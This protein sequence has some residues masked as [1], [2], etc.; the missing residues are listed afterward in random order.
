MHRTSNGEHRSLGGPLSNMHGHLAAVPVRWLGSI[1]RAA[2]ALS[3]GMPGLTLLTFNPLHWPGTTTKRNFEFR[4]QIRFR[5][6]NFN[7]LD[8]PS[9]SLSVTNFSLSLLVSFSFSQHSIAGS[10]V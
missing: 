7:F 8:D 3:L 2:R 9:F 10:I 6:L 5:F 4:G 1:C